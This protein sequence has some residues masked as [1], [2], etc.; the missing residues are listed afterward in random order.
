MY[1]FLTDFVHVLFGFLAVFFE[2]YLFTAIFLVKQIL[3][4]LSHKESWVE[5]SKDITEYSCGLVVGYLI[6]TFLL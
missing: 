4:Y 1:R 5:T 6:S 2:P 3:D